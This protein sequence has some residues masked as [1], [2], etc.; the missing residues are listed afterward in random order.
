MTSSLKKT[1]SLD[2]DQLF[3]DGMTQLKNKDWSGAISS[4]ETA[5][6]RHGDKWDLHYGLG[7]A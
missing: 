3:Q 2:I 1:P 7:M 6:Q 4:F 5:L